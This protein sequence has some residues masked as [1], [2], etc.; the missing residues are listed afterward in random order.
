MSVPL[1]T[2]VIRST[3]SI[4][5]DSWEYVYWHASPML[6][7]VFLHIQ[8]VLLHWCGMMMSSHYTGAITIWNRRQVGGLS[9]GGRLLRKTILPLA[10]FQRLS[11]AIF[12]FSGL[13]R[14]CTIFHAVKKGRIN[15]N[16][17]L[18]TLHT[19]GILM[20]GTEMHEVL[21]CVPVDGAC[22]F[23]HLS[24]LETKRKCGETVR[25]GGCGVR[26]RLLIP[27]GP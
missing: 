19:L 4:S 22:S 24:L 6:L 10:F 2:E 3:H 13:S 7:V 23:S 14:A 21:Q 1:L 12:A 15:V 11:S 18:L 9:F 27:A 26:V 8:N 5:Q 25:C 20:A 16:H 17:L